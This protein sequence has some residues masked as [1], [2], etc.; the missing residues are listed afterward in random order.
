[1]ER[2]YE[3]DTLATEQFEYIGDQTSSH[4]GLWNEHREGLVETGMIEARTESD[5]LEHRHINVV[6]DHHVD[7]TCLRQVG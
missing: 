7:V 1:M 2:L 6:I 3:I 4:V 5:Q